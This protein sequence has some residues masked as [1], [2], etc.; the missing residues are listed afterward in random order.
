MLL[1]QNVYNWLVVLNSSSGRENIQYCVTI[2]KSSSQYADGQRLSLSMATFSFDCQ[3]TN[4]MHQSMFEINC[5]VMLCP[6]SY[7][8]SLRQKEILHPFMLKSPLNPFW[9]WPLLPP[10]SS[11][12]SCRESHLILQRGTPRS[13]NNNLSPHQERGLAQNDSNDYQ[14]CQELN[15][16]RAN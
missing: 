11:T 12:L 9:P 7:V 16:T 13:P 5:Y 10:N 6:M 3:L 8:N 2:S 15:L 4:A 14:R 1:R